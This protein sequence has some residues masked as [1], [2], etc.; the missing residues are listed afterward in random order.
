MEK[1]LKTPRAETSAIATRALTRRFGE[2]TAVDNLDFSVSYGEIFGLLGA[3]GAG[4]STTIKMLTTLLPPTSGQAWVAGY[5]I[6]RSPKEVRRRIGYVPQLLSA[7]GGLTA[8]EN[9]TLSAKLYGIPRSERE[10]RTRAALD[11]MGLGDVAGK[12][13]RT[14]SGGM[15]RRLELALAMLHRP[16]VLFL[17]EPTIGLDPVVRRIVWERLQ[18]MMRERSMAILLTTH[19]MEEAGELCQRLA[20]LHRGAIAAL[21]SPAALKTSVGENASLEDVFAH[22]A[23]GTIQE[24][25]SYR[26]VRSTRNTANRLG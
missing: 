23:G 11:F 21:G 17:D 7:D 9:L 26:D 15:I 24:G 1:V 14:F 19:D 12:L 18:A 2:F 5:E 20:I 25:G 10:P 3:N 4:K 13:V 22:F 16:T 6:E 8:L